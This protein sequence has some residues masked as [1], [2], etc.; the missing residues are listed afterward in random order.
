MVFAQAV[1]QCDPRDSTTLLTD[2]DTN[3]FF[4]TVFSCLWLFSCLPCLLVW[5]FIILFECCQEENK[6]GRVGL[7][8]VMCLNCLLG[9]IYSLLRTD[10]WNVLLFTSSLGS[11]LGLLS[12]LKT[13]HFLFLESAFLIIFSVRLEVMKSLCLSSPFLPTQHCGFS[14]STENFT[15]GHF[16]SAKHREKGYLGIHML[17][18]KMWQIQ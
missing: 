1:V 15:A 16:P 10:F 11:F 13:L 5:Y 17:K 2:K 4:S 14:I 6:Q 7:V 9:K 12:C 3:S 8:Q 18:N